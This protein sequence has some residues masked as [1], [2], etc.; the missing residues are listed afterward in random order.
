MEFGPISKVASEKT[1]F[2]PEKIV[3]HTVSCAQAEIASKMMRASIPNQWERRLALSDKDLQK[4]N[5]SHHT[6][7]HHI[8]PQSSLEK[9]HRRSQERQTKQKDKN[10]KGKE[11][12]YMYAFEKAGALH[13]TSPHLQ[14]LK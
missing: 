4:K 13:N 14:C 8:T 10:K 3:S 7:P 9:R 1:S 5:L 11:R 6:T 2:K 12:R